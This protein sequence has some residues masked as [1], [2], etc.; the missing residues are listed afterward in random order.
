MLFSWV[1]THYYIIID[2][3]APLDFRL[4]SKSLER[5]VVIWDLNVP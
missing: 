5:K 2:M 4:D 1:A 3:S